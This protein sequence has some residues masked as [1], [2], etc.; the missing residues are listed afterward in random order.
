MTEAQ[1]RKIL[2]R[3][4]RQQLSIGEAAQ[5][6]Q[7]ARG[8]VD[9]GFAKIDT[10]RERRCGLPEIV[11][12]EGKEPEQVAQIM[13]HLHANASLILATRATEQIFSAVQRTLPTAIFHQAARL[14][15]VGEP[16]PPCG[17]TVLVLTAGTS[18]IPVAEEAAV[19]CGLLGNRIEREF[20]VGVAGVHRLLAHPEKI[21]S[22][23]VLIVVA[24]MD[25]VL[26]SLVGGLVSQPV[27]AL[28]TSQGYGASFQGLA[29]LLTMLNSCA[30]GVAVVNIDNGLG[31][32]V[33]ASRINQMNLGPD[34]A[35]L[36][37]TSG[38]RTRRR[39]AGLSARAV[40]PA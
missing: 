10:D 36:V 13:R 38:S 5:Q 17:G 24:G 2:E 19:T 15:S 32:G 21:Q 35:H 18:D 6:I 4:R 29:A 11:F 30:P 16:K 8:F 22:A 34:V 40:T 37:A 20:D 33:L 39:P 7:M 26:P 1:L 31:A 27:I 25:G 23:S 14:I 12:C 9:V 3:V 28:P